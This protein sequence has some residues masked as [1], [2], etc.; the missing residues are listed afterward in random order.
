MKNSKSLNRFQAIFAISLITASP[1]L[2]AAT[3]TWGSGATG[4][5]SVGSNWL[6]SSSPGST[7]ILT[8]ADTAIFTNAAVSTIT[9]DS[10]TQ[11]IGSITFSSGTNTIGASGA[12]A[13]NSLLLSSGGAITAL[14]SASGTINAPIVLEP[15]SST[16]AGSYTISNNSSKVMT[17]GGNIT[18]GTTTG[19]ITLNLSG[20]NTTAASNNLNG[21]ISDGSAALGLSVVKSEAGTWQLAAA[22]TYTG[23]TVINTGTLSLTGAAG[24]AA[25]SSGFTVN[26]G[27]TLKL[28]NTNTANNTNRIGNSASITLSGGQFQF[29]T[30]GAA[31][32]SETV[33]ALTATKG[34]F[35]RIDTTVAGSQTS[36]ALTISSIA[37]GSTPNSVGSVW[38]SGLTNADTAVNSKNEIRLTTAPTTVGGIL[39][40]AVV[41]GTATVSSSNTGNW[42]LSTVTGANNNVVA[43]TYT[44]A[45]TDP[46]TWSSAMNVKLTSANAVTLPAGTTTI[47]SLTISP[48]SPTATI[49]I[50]SNKLVVTSGVILL[51][52]VFGGASSNNIVFTQSSS[53]ALTAGDG[54]NPATLRFFSAVPAAGNYLTKVLVPITDNGS[55]SVNLEWNAGTIGY[56]NQANTYTGNTYINNGGYRIDATNVIK[57]GAGYGDWYVNR[58]TLQ[59]SFTNTMN[60]LFGGGG[61]LFNPSGAPITLSVGANNISS[62]FSGN[63]TQS[64][65]GG[66]I[67]KVGNGTLTLSGSNSYAG[68]TTIS[69]GTMEITSAGTINSTSGVNIGAGEFKY[70]SATALSQAVS[71]TSTGGTLSGT[72]T[73]T[74]AVTIGAGNT[75]SPGNSIGTQAFGTGLTIAG[76]YAAQLGGPGASDLAAVTGTLGLSGIL[77][78]SDDANASGK[79]WAGAGA[80]RLITYTTTR[81]GTF[82]SVTNPMSST[83][84]EKVNYGA[85]SGG[86]AV[87]LNLYNLATA[88]TLSTSISLGKVHVGGALS[89]ALSIQNTGTNTSFTEGL[90]ASGGSL[91]GNAT[92]SGG[93]TNLAAGSTDSSSL[94]VG[95]STANAGAKT[96]TV[97]ISLASNGST[98]SGYGNTALTGQTITVNGEVYNLASTGFST[99]SINLGAVHANGSFGTQALS[100]GN[101]LGSSTYNETLAAQLANAS[102]VSASGTSIT[103]VAGAAADTSLALGLTASTATA[104]HKSGTVD[105][106]FTSDAVNG[107]GLGNT[108]L[109]ALNK[110]VTVSG[111]VYSGAGVW[112]KNGGGSYGSLADM[113]NWTTNG[114][115]PGLDSNFAKDDT[116]TFGNGV[117]AGTVT[118]DGATPSLKALTFDNASGSYTLAAGSSGHVILNNGT[119]AATVTGSSGSH[120]IS[121]DVALQSNL[122]ASVASGA[123]LVI[124]GGLSGSDKTLSKSDAGILTLSGT[125]TYSGATTVSGGKLVVD[126]SITSAVTVNSG[127]TLGGHGSTGALTVDN[128]GIIAPGNSPGALTVERAT[129]AAGSIFSLDLTTNGTGTAGVDWDQ[130]KVTGLLDLSGATAGGIHLNLVNYNGFTFDPSTSHTW[131]SFITFGSVNGYNADRFAI[132]ASAFGGTGTWSVVQASNALD[133][134]YQMVPEPATWAMLVGGLG[135]LAFG[136][137]LRRRSA[138]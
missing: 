15:A 34:Y 6:G 68:A 69:S 108:A 23:S 52:Q 115:A 59:I 81:S 58:G 60:G 19:G 4:N 93:I 10:S 87:D 14:A 45:E 84:H 20:T 109:T 53:A 16:T 129:L 1:A 121:A 9:I 113:S 66:G 75:L 114:G 37:N 98:T 54:T 118:L 22:N 122:N 91:T 123:S 67:T 64:G 32:F 78:L 85:A 29:A 38:F 61:L 99:T 46:A 80:Y 97:T 65:S 106:Q 111:D 39:P 50:G 12:N 41:G 126:G 13:G 27:A 104:G 95:L 119:S 138:Q 33:G 70:N 2:H 100:I 47:N 96:G 72:G 82:A 116:A 17:I 5:W 134:Q 56:T 102:G 3:I 62:T 55:S 73:I 51:N 74:P 90:N 79:G 36:Q 135:M 71:F 35:N 105:V 11:N 124:S 31:A 130:L 24:A 83:L 7:S 136:Q 40:W 49:A 125:S 63:I 101:T 132:D 86:G 103:V 92:T 94:L 127:A 76:T 128:G 107:S 21:V 131:D 26:Q 57:N 89:Q 28:D 8:N 25:S 88:N 18:G 44:G 117:T 110:T 120:T 77:S 48:S 30:S 133:L 43:Y 112:N 42:A 137:R